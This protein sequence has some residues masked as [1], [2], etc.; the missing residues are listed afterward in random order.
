MRA[1]KC[2][3]HGTRYLMGAGGR[4][5]TAEWPWDESSALDC[6]G[7][8]AWALGHNRE[9][10]PD[11]YP[12]FPGRWIESTAIVKDAKNK[13]ILFQQI[14]ME[15]V[16]PGDVLAYGDHKTRSG[17]VGLVATSDQRGPLAVIHCSAANW[18]VRLDAIGETVPGPWLMNVDSIAAR[19]RLIQH[20][21][22]VA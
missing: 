5:A 3:G 1:R 18:R 2:I 12:E 8:L 16:L 22:A 7:F 6:T 9:L 19:C 11:E 15:I 20:P 21:E 10:K 17:H 13:M 4:D 14:P